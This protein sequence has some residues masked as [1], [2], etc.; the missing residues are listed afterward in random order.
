[1]LQAGPRPL[2]ENLW[3]QL[4][5]VSQAACLSYYTSNNVKALK[6]IQNTEPHN[7]YHQHTCH[8]FMI[9]LTQTQRP[10]AGY[11]IPVLEPPYW[12]LVKVL[13]PTRHKIGHF[14]DARPSQSLD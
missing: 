14:G 1:M 7:H 3:E 12:L 13:H 6:G 11:L 9:H 10:Y 5:Q 4:Y 8:P 2:N